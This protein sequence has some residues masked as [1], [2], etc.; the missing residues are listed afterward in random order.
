MPGLVDTSTERVDI[1]SK[2]PDCR[3]RLRVQC[4]RR[5]QDHLAVPV[6]VREREDQCTVEIE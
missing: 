1:P 5:P 3:E 2:S 6:T 4:G